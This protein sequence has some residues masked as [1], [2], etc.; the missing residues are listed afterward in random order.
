MQCNLSGRIL[1]G[2]N[3]MLGQAARQEDLRRREGPG[4]GNDAYALRF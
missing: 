4:R 1:A 3:A 2:W